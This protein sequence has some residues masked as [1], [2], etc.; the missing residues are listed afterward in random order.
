MAYTSEEL[1][2]TSERAG[3]PLDYLTRLVAAD[4]H[5]PQDPDGNHVLLK[6][7]VVVFDHH[8][9]KC[10]ASPDPVGALRQFGFEETADALAEA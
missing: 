2:T 7:L 1:R 3:I 9:A 4:D 5:D 10:F 8:V 6:K